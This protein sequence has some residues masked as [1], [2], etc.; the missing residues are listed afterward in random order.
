MGSNNTIKRAAP[1]GD[2]ESV[3]C[4]A[5][6]CKVPCG[7][8][9]GANPSGQVGLVP[10]AASERARGRPSPLIPE[11]PRPATHTQRVHC[12]GP[13]ADSHQLYLQPQPEKEADREINKQ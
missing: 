4:D 12:T 11:S 6:V 7:R 3:P 5:S 9:A 2:G 10:G 1:G 8:S 13:E